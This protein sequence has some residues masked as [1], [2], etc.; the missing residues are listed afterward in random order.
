MKHLDPFMSKLNTVIVCSG[1]GTRLSPLTLNMPKCLIPVY[2][3]A[4]LLKQYRALKPH[5]DIWLIANS[6]YKRLLEQFCRIHNLSIGLLWHD[7]ADGSANAI[8]SVCNFL[9]GQRVL[10]HWSDLLCET[11]KPFTLLTS[12]TVGLKPGAKYRYEHN[13]KTGFL[14]AGCGGVVGVYYL[15]DYKPIQ[16]QKCGT[17][18]ADIFIRYKP[19]LVEVADYGKLSLLPKQE[20]KI[21]RS[22]PNYKQRITEIWYGSE[23]TKPKEPD[24]NWLI[25]ASIYE[26]KYQLANSI[27]IEDSEAKRMLDDAFSYLSIVP[28]EHIRITDIP[29]SY[30]LAKAAYDL[31][32]VQPIQQYPEIDLMSESAKELCLYPFEILKELMTELEKAWC[33]V[34]LLTAFGE[35]SINPIKQSLSFYLGKELARELL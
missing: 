5:S 17:D 6:C 15:H 32:I 31:M 16:K 35:Y 20:N 14:Q 4:L 2:G 24:I 9:E 29:I 3:E 26:Y 12:N 28:D 33:V 8:A 10:F 13:K 19:L 7:R 18:W 27:L 21:I 34:F 11:Y 1:L 23:L 25:S 22:I 30:E